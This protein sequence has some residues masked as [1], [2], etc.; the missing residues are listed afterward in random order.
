MCTECRDVVA[1]CSVIATLV[2]YLLTTVD[3]QNPCTRKVHTP[4]AHIHTHMQ[5]QLV[6]SRQNFLSVTSDGMHALTRADECDWLVAIA[7]DL[8]V[9]DKGEVQGESTV[10]GVIGLFVWSVCLTL[11]TP[12]Y[13]LGVAL[14][15]VVSMWGR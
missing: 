14:V 12:S 5:I 7:G 1:L 13:F 11:L 8:S 4:F 6:R 2:P 10:Q 15:F 3:A 9:S